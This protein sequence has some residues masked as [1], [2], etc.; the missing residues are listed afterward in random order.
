MKKMGSGFQD[1]KIWGL[2]YR[3]CLHGAQAGM[4]GSCHELLPDGKKNLLDDYDLFHRAES[5]EGGDGG[6]DVNRVDF[7]VADI[8]AL[9]VP[10]SKLIMSWRTRA[11][12]SW[13]Q[14]SKMTRLK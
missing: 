1:D 11:P 13:G 7:P 3:L 8:V 5:A 10:M 4:T 2:T 12:G 14:A 9:I 6:E